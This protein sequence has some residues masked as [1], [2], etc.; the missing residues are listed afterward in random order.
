MYSACYKLQNDTLFLKIKQK[1]TIYACLKRKDNKISDLDI[2]L[3]CVNAFFCNS[4]AFSSCIAD[5]H[6]S[7]N[8]DQCIWKQSLS[9]IRERIHG[10]ALRIRIRIM[11]QC[12]KC[13]IC[14]VCTT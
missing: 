7:C 10:S 5:K 6:A 4:A 1:M 11:D 2:F 12:H 8:K 13:S 9:Y 14:D 3:R